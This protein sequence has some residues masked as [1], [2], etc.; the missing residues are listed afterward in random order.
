[1]RG[2]R[3]NPLVSRLTN[4]LN[5]QGDIFAGQQQH[6]SPKLF[7]SGL[8]GMSP[9]SLPAQHFLSP[10]AQRHIYLHQ[11]PAGDESMLSR[12]HRCSLFYIMTMSVR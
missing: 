9:E 4:S 11:G 7:I 5:N 3:P 6:I 1:M 10:Q 12:W 8:I 2:G